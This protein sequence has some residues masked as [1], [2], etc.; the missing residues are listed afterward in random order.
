M[1]LIALYVFP[2]RVANARPIPTV[3]FRIE[4][5]EKT[6]LTVRAV[7]TARPGDFQLRILAKGKQIACM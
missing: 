5:E 2:E 6:S 4:G 7:I 3:Q 1:F